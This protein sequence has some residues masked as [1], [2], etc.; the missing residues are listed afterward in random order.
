MYELRSTADPCLLSCLL[1]ATRG[2][3]FRRRN[4]IEFNET[5]SQIHRRHEAN[6]MRGAP[7]GG[8]YVANQCTPAEAM[9][10]YLNQ[11]AQANIKR[12][13]TDVSLKPKG[14]KEEAGGDDKEGG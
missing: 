4:V 7:D 3:T 6:G 10:K 9:L 1:Q 14:L 13:M 5:P 12:A 2:K 8:F 11:E